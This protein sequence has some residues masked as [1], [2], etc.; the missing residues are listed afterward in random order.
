MD[1]RIS[2]KLARFGRTL[3][4]VGKILA[5][6]CILGAVSALFIAVLAAAL[7]ED[8]IIGILGSIELT[9]SVFDFAANAHLSD[10]IAPVA[11]ISLK[12][13]TIIFAASICI[14]C[15]LSAVILFIL[16]A[17]FKA[18]AVHRTPFLQENVKRLKIIGVIL[19]VASF[20]LGLTNL[21]FAFCVLAFAYVFQYGTELQQQADETL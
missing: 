10:F 13:L 1:T 2:D 15:L 14:Y 20:L 5:I 8:A 9:S 7:P 4:V 19:I 6:V 16:S 18:T 3:D 11:I 21:I 12:V 17:V